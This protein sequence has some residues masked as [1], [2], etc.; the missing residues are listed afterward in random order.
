MTFVEQDPAEALKLLQPEEEIDPVGQAFGAFKDLGRSLWRGGLGEFTGGDPLGYST[1]QGLLDYFDQ[2]YPAD[3]EM[4]PTVTPTLDKLIDEAVITGDEPIDRAAVTTDAIIKSLH[5]ERIS[6]EAGFAKFINWLGRH[7][8]TSVRREGDPLGESI[9]WETGALG[10]REGRDQVEMLDLS[11]DEG[12]VR[13]KGYLKNNWRDIP[14]IVTLVQQNL[15][16]NWAEFMAAVG[17][18]GVRP[19]NYSQG[20]LDQDEYRDVLRQFG[21]F[22]DESAVLATID[23][24]YG[25]GSA[26]DVVSGA[27]DEALNAMV[28]DIARTNSTMMLGPVNQPGIEGR[29]STIEYDKEG[30]IIE[31]EDIPGEQVAFITSFDGT[32]YGEIKTLND[33]MSGGLIGP[34]NAA[35]H[36]KDLYMNTKDNT[37]YSAVLEKVQ[38]DLFALGVMEEPDEWGKLDIVNI[39]L[40]DDE[41]I[42]AVQMIQSDLINA[43]LEAWGNAQRG[44]EPMAPDGSPY[45]DNVLARLVSR[46]ISMG[47]TMAHSARQQEQTILEQVSKKIQDRVAMDPT[48]GAGQGGSL[49]ARGIT[50]VD[51]AIRELIQELSVA[52]REQYLGRGGSAVQRQLV[53]SVL[54][55][56]YD[57]EDWGSEAFFAG[58]NS[59]NDFMRYALNVGAVSQEQVNLLNRGLITTDTFR[60]SYSAEDMQN[61]ERDVMTATL[62]KYATKHM[63]EGVTEEE[64]L[65]RGLITFARTVGQRTAVDNNYSDRDYARMASNAMNTA[66]ASP[67]VSPLVTTLEERLAESY[68]LTGGTTSGDFGNLMDTLNR[69]RRSSARLRVR[70]V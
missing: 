17:T 65:R 10:P 50:E 16:S 23:E 14:E 66:T 12:Q 29:A 28:V 26:I 15:T 70:N 60:N 19:P 3:P 31:E 32:P 56:F 36:M 21:A 67:A 55:Q 47:D 13:L 37:G 22:G 44:G 64:A 58:Q 1:I 39:E 53:D 42:N 49:S 41:T 62:L 11:S 18:T 34:M 8:V 6:S 63:G 38:Q 68:N 48:R 57:D 4:R 40:G 54:S 35:R 24:I 30:N 69:R 33:L 9:V 20:V 61:A 25:S 46:S 52:E 5:F 27:L 7:G 45:L 2:T 43:G 59:D 51:K